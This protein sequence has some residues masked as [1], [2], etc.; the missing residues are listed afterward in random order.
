M[1]W[2]VVTYKSINWFQL[3]LPPQMAKKFHIA[4]IKKKS[5]MYANGYLLP[6]QLFFIIEEM[7]S[8]LLE[9]EACSTTK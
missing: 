5:H 9:L 2:L 6:F 4:N 8:G 7:V 1:N 3:N